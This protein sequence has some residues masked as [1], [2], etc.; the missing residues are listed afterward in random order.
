MKE[1][2]TKFDLEAAFKALDELEL[3]K[4]EKG[5]KANKPALTEIFA[6]KSKFDSLFE[7]YYDVGNTGELEDAK[8]AREA[9]IAKAKL[10]RIEKI[11]D[12]D[13][14]SPEDLLTSYV[15]KY[16]I[17]CP[18]CLTLFY[19][20][21]EDVEE[22]EDDPDLVNVNEVCQHCGNESGYTLVG[23]VGEA[24]AGEFEEAEAELENESTEEV[25]EDDLDL[26]D[27]ELDLE[28]DDEELEELDIDI[29]DDEELGSEENTKEESF[30]LQTSTNNILTEKLN[31]ASELDVSA[32]EFEKLISSTEFKKPIAD[33]EVRGMMQE[34]TKKEQEVSEATKMDKENTNKLTEGVGAETAN[35][36]KDVLS[37]INKEE[38]KQ[39]WTDTVANIIEL[40]P[41]ELIDDLFDAAKDKL[42]NVKL[43]D[44][45]KKKIIDL[46]GDK[47]DGEEAEDADTL[48][49]IL[50]L[51][52]I[53]SWDAANLK[54]YLIAV[55]GIIAV[56]EPT[57]ILEII[58]G[59]VAI[60]PADI[61]KKIL[62][63]TNISNIIGVA[64]TALNRGY[65]LLKNLKNEKKE[66]LNTDKLELEEGILDKVKDKISKA[67]DNITS[68]LKSREAKADWL[69]ANAI[70]EDS[71]I[72]TDS[73]GKILID[74]KNRK[75]STF[76]VIGFK[77][78]YS[79]GK[80]ITMAP[81]YNNKD[82]IMGMEKPELKESYEE[83][84]NKAKGWSMKQGNGPA[85]IYM[86]KGPA[87]NNAVF[88]CEYFKGELKNDQLEKYF[89]ATKQDIEACKLMSKGDAK[90]SEK[91]EEDTT[92]ESL[93]T[94]MNKVEEL[95]ESVLEQQIATSLVK[96]YKNVAGFKLTNCT[97]LNEKFNVEGRVFFTSGRARNITYAFSEALLENNK[98]R[99]FGINE[100]LGLKNQFTITGYADKNSKNFIIESFEK[101]NK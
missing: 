72:S 100:K 58:T 17:Q 70:K 88:L 66:D 4:A 55:L 33:S 19:K 84:D 83:A 96:E 89:E 63:I 79:N 3:P 30:S 46:A 87:D 10:D 91:S 82:L 13:A 25:T 47:L 74:D 71:T 61:V 42:S 16:I 86:A 73:S 23:K 90:V 85:F 34:L 64:G 97:Y 6:R 27:E 8:E 80:L 38:S 95:Q 21:P 50:S 24:E 92:T 77:E 98:V 40:I 48:G 14:K 59:I 78:T 53:T 101:I 20:N 29:E 5:I 44:D 49:K 35:A 12:L 65:Q 51:F 2:I 41:D 94:F 45:T 67:V 99:L 75:F 15:G 28:L 54:K 26:S 9:E 32:D 7:E 18:Q 56:I 39:G 1:S 31:E 11:V 69:L 36:L 60:L 62:T 52:D 22:S 81:S 68:K 37:T 43:N 76:V 57:P 93:N